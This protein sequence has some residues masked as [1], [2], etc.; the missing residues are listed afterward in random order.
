MLTEITKRYGDVPNEV[1]E[2]NKDMPIEQQVLAIAV[3]IP[4][5]RIEEFLR[6]VQ[7]TLGLSV[8]MMSYIALRITTFAYNA[9]HN[10]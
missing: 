7:H 5:D 9:P 10:N 3:K 8:D 6:E 4:C 1:F 2:R